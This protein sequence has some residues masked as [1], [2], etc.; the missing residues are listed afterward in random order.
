MAT[1]V[2]QSDPLPPEWI[3]LPGNQCCHLF[4]YN[5]PRLPC[6]LLHAFLGLLTSMTI[7]GLV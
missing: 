5:Q 3:L 2:M 6:Q 1:R 4:A 7:L